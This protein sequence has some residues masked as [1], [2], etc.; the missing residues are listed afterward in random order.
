V[1]NSVWVL[2]RMSRHMRHQLLPGPLAVVVMD[3]QDLLDGTLLEAHLLE[4]L[5]E[6]EKLPRLW[7]G[8][9]DTRE[10]VFPPYVFPI[11][12]V[13]GSLSHQV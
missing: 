5:E 1:L 10:S 2:D 3:Q 13:K 11:L 6:A 8:I 12:N 9:G 7:K 4:L